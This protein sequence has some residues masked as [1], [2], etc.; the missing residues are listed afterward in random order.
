MKDL[1][2]VRRV[3]G[4]DIERDRERGILTISQSGYIREF[5]MDDQ[6]VCQRLLMH[7]SNWLP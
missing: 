6:R 7:I 1:G 4:M 5:N 2:P 3:L